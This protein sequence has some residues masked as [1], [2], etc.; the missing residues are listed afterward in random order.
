MNYLDAINYG[1]KILKLS[2]SNTYNLDSELLLAKA[3][4]TS[5]EYLLINLSKKIKLKILI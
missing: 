3:L 4:N 1:N 2:N 5:R